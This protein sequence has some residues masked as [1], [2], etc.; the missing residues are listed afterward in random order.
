MDGKVISKEEEFFLKNKQGELEFTLLAEGIRKL[1]LLWVLIQNGTLLKGSVLLW[2]EPE[3][4]LNPRLMRTVVEILVALQ[5][6]GVQIFLT[7]HNYVILKEF[8]LKT[9]ADGDGQIL[10]HSLYR[11]KSGELEVASTGDYLSI[12]P[13]AIDDTFGRIIDREIEKSMGKLRKIM[14]IERR[15]V[16][17]SILQMPLMLL[18]LMKRINRSLHTTDCRFR[19]ND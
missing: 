16:L 3:T 11:N 14:Q 17:L 6:I 18:F 15:T 9:K 12:S 2:D 1:A 4:N 7:T 13:N 8:D 10:Y 19:R 5:Q